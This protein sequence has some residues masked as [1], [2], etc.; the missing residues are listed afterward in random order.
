MCNQYTSTPAPRLALKFKV[1]APEKPYAALISPLGAAPFITLES[2]AVVGQWGMIPP[3]SAT[4]I[5][6]TTLGKR[7]STNN[8]RREGM[9]KSWTFGGAWQKGQRC[10]IPADVFYEPNWESGA[11]V[12]W[13]FQRADGDPWALAGLWSTWTDPET[14]EIVPNFTL[15][16]QN[17][18]AHPLLSRMHKP[19]PRF[20]PELQ[21]K[22]AVVPVERAQ[23]DEWL[24]GSREQA[25]RLIRLPA[26][27]LFDDG[28]AEPPGP[29]KPPLKSPAK[30]PAKQ[31]VTSTAPDPQGCLF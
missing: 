25:E 10:L 11:H 9:A 27:D 15:I 2:G 7:L 18:D 8:A 19:D 17:C 6:R 22:R 4:R 29:S 26:L 14:G 24:G 5:P 21:D 20:A 28:P 1:A 30:L 13:R 16:T 31:P 3:D 23:W 12:R